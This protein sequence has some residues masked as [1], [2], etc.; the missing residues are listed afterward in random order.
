[1]EQNRIPK[2]IAI[3][4]DGNGR[5]AKKRLMPRTYGHSEGT[6]TL[7]KIVT[8]C[9]KIGVE[10]LTVYAFSTE[11]WKRSSSEV[12]ALMI[13]FKYYLKK[14]EET[15]MENGTRLIISGSKENISLELLDCMNNLVEKTKNNKKLT[16]NIAFNYG[17]RQEIV[18]GINNIIKSGM[19]SI[20]EEDMKKFLYNNIPDPELLIRTSGEI[21]LSNFLLWQIAYSEIHITEKLWPDFEE[22]D[23]EIAIL[24]FQKRD[25]RYGGVKNVK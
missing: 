22:K 3:I 11:N 1:M 16:L 8:H 2:H 18:D 14:E 19:E 25:R 17:G 13:L 9:Q 15:F 7:K 21:R 6:K 12:E 24:E 23:L 20:T 5:W 10:Y 4:M